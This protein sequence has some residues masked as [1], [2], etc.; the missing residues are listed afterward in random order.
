MLAL[1]LTL[2]GTLRSALRTRAQLALGLQAF[3]N[4][5]TKLAR[6]RALLPAPVA[7]P[8]DRHDGDEA[9]PA[10]AIDP[11]LP[12]PA[13]LLAL[14]GVDVLRC[15]RCQQRT[16]VRE[17]LPPARASPVVRKAACAS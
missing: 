3:S 11:T 12:W 16:I 9:S 17:L 5:S 4:A 6:A 7:D 15:P 14:T 8:V 1:L 13:L 10:A 2:L